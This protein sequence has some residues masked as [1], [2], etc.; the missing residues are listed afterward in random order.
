[1][2]FDSALGK[3]WESLGQES[4]TSVAEDLV[5]NFRCEMPNK[6]VYSPGPLMQ[7]DSFSALQSREGFMDMQG[8]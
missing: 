6:T 7:V 4:F 8:S 3:P 2:T 5:V 1:M